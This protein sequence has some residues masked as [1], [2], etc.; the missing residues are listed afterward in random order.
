MVSVSG[1]E[2]LPSA[3]GSEEPVSEFLFEKLLQCD[4]QNHISTMTIAKNASAPAAPPTTAAI[5][6]DMSQSL[7]VSP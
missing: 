7:C 1:N 4:L 2:T 5:D 6:F 3:D